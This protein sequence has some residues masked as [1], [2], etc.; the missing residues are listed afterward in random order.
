MINLTP[1]FCSIRPLRQPRQPAVLYKIAIAA[2]IRAAVYSV[3]LTQ[4]IVIG[5]L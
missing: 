2:I 1:V 3:R 4:L 5:V